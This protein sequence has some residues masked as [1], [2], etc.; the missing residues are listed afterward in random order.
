MSWKISKIQISSFKAF[1]EITLDFQDASLITLDGPNGFGKTSVF[2]AIELVLTASISRVNRLF[3]KIMTASK[4]NYQD[5]LYWNIRSTNKDLVIKIE[6]VDDDKI[7]ILARRASI[8][9]LKK[10]ETNRATNFHAFKLYELEDFS[11]TEF[12]DKNRRNEDFVAQTF[13]EG[14]RDNY[15]FLNYLEQGQSEY[16]FATRIDQRK[17]ALESLINTTAINNDIEKCKKIEAKLTK[18]LDSKSRN[19][20]IEQ[21]KNQ[22]GDLE[23]FL[24]SGLGIS[25]YAKLSS[26]QIQPDWDKTNILATYNAILHEKYLQAVREI[27]E[28]LPYKDSIRIKLSNDRLESYISRHDDVLEAL[29][30]LGKTTDNL[31]LLEST[32]KELD[33]YQSAF[34]SLQ[35]AAQSIKME[36]IER[37]PDWEVESFPELANNLITRDELARQTRTSTEAVA[38]LDSLKAEIVATHAS[39]SP[40]TRDC[41]LC[42]QDWGNHSALMDAI[43]KK[44]ASVKASLNSIEKSYLG[45]CAAI[46]IDLVK[47]AEEITAKTTSLLSLF[48]AP[49]YRLLASQ[50]EKIDKIKVLEERLV[51]M[52]VSYPDNFTNDLTEVIRRKENLLTAMRSKKTA[53]LE[54]L[55]E[56]WHMTVQVNFSKSEDFY[57]VTESAVN[58]K[59]NY[60]THRAGNA[61]NAAL[62]HARHDLHKLQTEAYAIT[63][64]K[65]K[66]VKLRALLTDT[67]KSYS[68]QTIAEIELVFHIY[69]G[70]LIQNYQRGLGLFIES[71]DGKQLRFVTAEQSDHD[72]ILSMST[73]QISA[74]SLAFFFSLNRVYS[75]VPIIMI[76]D[77]SQS[78]DEVNIASLTDLLRCELKDCQLILASHEEEVSSYMRYRFQKANLIVKSLHMQKLVRSEMENIG[79]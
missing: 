49:L 2:D 21:L 42:G 6:F 55:P 50:Q 19:I 16:L 22:I 38:T 75:K 29:A 33:L 3:S 4:V 64:V 46:N 44:S 43:A 31:P 73:G 5:N 40:D 70:R 51:A 41:P 14:F 17:T 63:E 71:R 59:L 79:Q 56:H 34:S 36:V 47:I 1:K 28:L 60:I 72:A 18:K 76:D 53:E 74:L 20:R 12:T 54:A 61:R 68:D 15:S 26:S 23:T 39:I 11:A 66:V 48:N 67:E 24:V 77:P 9:A 78:L 65:N 52:G 8:A 35:N 32:K 30:Q 37:F 69:S 10:I 7:V 25:D 13:G 62:I 57:A 45:I 58:E 27:G